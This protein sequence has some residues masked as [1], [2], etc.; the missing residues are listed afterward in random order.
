MHIQTHSDVIDACRFCFM[1]RHLDTTGNVSFR[2]AD[3]P[4]GRA[5]VLDRIRMNPQQ[6]ANPDFI[7]AM[8]QSTLS[9]A[10]RKHCVSHYD[11]AGLVLQARHD[12]VEQN[13][14]PDAV[15]QLV[16]S[17]EQQFA[18]KLI[19]EGQDVLI[20]ST[21]EDAFEHQFL[22]L[23]GKTVQML[24]VNDTGKTP[25]VLG[26]WDQAKQMA[27]QITSLIKKSG[28]MT[29]VTNSPAAFDALKNDY[30]KWGIDWDGI[31]IE[32]SSTYL[33]RL[34]D[35]GKV[36]LSTNDQSVYYIDSDYLRNY[37]D[38]VT[39]PRQLLEQSGYQ[40]KPFGTNPE[41]SYAL[42]EAAMVMDQLYPRLVELM[43]DRFKNMMD[44]AMDRIVTASP[45]TL[46][47][48][49][50]AGIDVMSLEEALLASPANV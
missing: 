13:L 36:T 15:S 30:P 9:A 2:E 12:I 42:G 14:A 8:Y 46:R 19:G 10:C 33:A 44:Q 7:N 21:H 50:G 25:F 37:N 1:C 22:H 49:R 31:T 16:Q 28:C 23:T 4:R 11:E 41:E 39:E 20:L 38:I 27:Q 3:T 34:V 45:Y 48:L 29:V 24:H 26:F 5:L 32:H 17:I 6:L 43:L 18:P 47:I 40:L 35:A